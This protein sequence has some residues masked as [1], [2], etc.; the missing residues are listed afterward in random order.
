MDG[1]EHEFPWIIEHGTAL[2]GHVRGEFLWNERGIFQHAPFSLQCV[3]GKTAVHWVLIP[4]GPQLMSGRSGISR[5]HPHS[6]VRDSMS[7]SNIHIPVGYNSDF[8]SPQI[9]MCFKKLWIN[10]VAALQVN[11][12]L[13]RK[14]WLK[15]DGYKRMRNATWL[16][17]RIVWPELL[18]KPGSDVS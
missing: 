3:V 6:T 17:S 4:F 15:D 5:N 9:Q 7:Y 12:S 16:I 10:G 8:K 14:I 1:Y 2:S 13:M 11:E 18:T